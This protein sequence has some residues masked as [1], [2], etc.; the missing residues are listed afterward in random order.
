MLIDSHLTKSWQEK[1]KERDYVGEVGVD[2]MMILNVLE[3]YGMCRCVKYN[4]Y[5]GL[6]RLMF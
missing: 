2:R 5:F 3:R 6:D 1:L 4:C